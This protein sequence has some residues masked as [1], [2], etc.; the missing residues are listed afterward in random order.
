M[1]RIMSRA[2]LRVLVRSA[3]LMAAAVMLSGCGWIKG[4]AINTVGNTLAETSTSV[5]SD[6]DPDLIGDAFPYTIKFYE[7]IV[8]AA[9]NNDAMLLATCTLSTEYAYAFL[10]SKADILDR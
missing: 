1:S 6:N 2:R 7:A 9:P 4:M 10:Q 5:T 3:A 8:E